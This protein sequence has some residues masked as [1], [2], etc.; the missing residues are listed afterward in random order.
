MGVISRLFVSVVMAA[1]LASTGEAGQQAPSTPWTTLRLDQALAEL[2]RRGLRLI[3]S[4]EV[5]RPEMRVRTEPV[6]ASA[7]RMLDDL[8]APHGLIA[9]EGPGGTVLV[10]KNP[11][12]RI[13]TASP[14]SKSPASSPSVAATEDSSRAAAAP[15]FQQTVDVVDAA[16][17]GASGGPGATAASPELLRASAGSLE[18]VFRV[19]QSRPGVTSTDELGSR[20]AV[21][22]GSPDQNL[23][24]MDGVDIHNPY[25]LNIPSEELALAGAASTFNSD[26]I[27]SVEFFPGAFD[28]RH[29]DR[30]S[31]LLVVRNREGAEDESVKGTAFASLADSSL[32]VE[33]KLPRGSS[34][35]WLVSARRS[36][37]DLIAE[38]VLNTTLP[39]FLDVH[40]RFAWRLAPRRKL[41]LVSTAGRERTSF[42]DPA[43][44]D[45]GQATR[46]QS[47]LFALTFEASTAARVFSRTTAS[48][49]DLHDTLNAYERSFDNS[50]G[51]N[52]I[53][54]V[55][56]GGLLSF[57]LARDV[58]VRD[59]ALRQEWVF[60]PSVRHVFEFGAEAHG[61]DTQWAWNI[62]GDRSQSQPNGSSI[63]LG[64][65]LPE[66][67][68]SSRDTVR[69]G[70]WVQDRWKINQDV[71]VQ[72]GVR[73]D[74]STV[75]GRTTLSPRVS[76][77]LS[78]PHAVRLDAAVA[79]HTQTPGYEKLLQA[80]YFV[81]LSPQTAPRLDAERALHMVVGARRAFGSLGVRVDA[82][83]KRFS[84][85][86][87]G[88]LETDDQ[89]LA[90]VATYDVPLALRDSVATGAQITTQPVNA[91]TGRAHGV[92]VEVSH[93]GKSA[94]TPLTGWVSYS[95]G[96][97]NRSAYGYTVP[98][99]Y[100]RRHAFSA[101]AT[102]KIGSRVDFSANARLGTGLPRTPVQG[103]RL[104][105]EK[106]VADADGD[107]VRDERIPQRDALG[108]PVFQP[109]LGDVTR[110]NSARLPHFARIDTRLTFRPTWNGERWAFY[111][112]FVNVINS[113]NAAQ[114]DTAIV[115]D[116]SSDRPRIVER[117]VDR[118]VPFFP[119]A[120]LRFWF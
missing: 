5:V 89:R 93:A 112:D 117:V 28:V 51:A 97:A 107:G 57:Q 40:A 104:A 33:G 84:D 22:G 79:V 95:F 70:A 37:L 111:V 102:L 86:I 69:V 2:Q 96:R 50:R 55:S 41:S 42:A 76:A 20:L 85:L 19:L 114:I 99:D 74:R 16:S 6:P 10:V 7:R 43:A 35:S 87:V 48:L 1:L 103:V 81:D 46:A 54:S 14:A 72:P 105:L 83:V 53:L 62:A 67:L 17:I 73:L 21:R 77:T 92:E 68:D 82:Y 106:D 25:R 4:S 61:L 71:V 30:L 44:I 94:S 115:Y 110:I 27:E 120:G 78:L 52:N 109:D 3:F 29:G 47:A 13:G 60:A 8:L 108:D 91:A 56:T 9:R 59:L 116:P 45:A 36:H 18:N 101:A 15:R 34:G 80:D 119:F 66:S 63:R 75:T 90:R 38:R 64:T 39:A 113:R 12:A 49:S 26:T 31:S 58:A 98:F 65:S 11:R 32:V 100:D 24:V 118:G 23:T 88:Q